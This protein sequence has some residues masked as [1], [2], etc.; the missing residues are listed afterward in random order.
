MTLAEYLISLGFKIDETSYRKFKEA[1][2]SIGSNTFKLG[3]LVAETSGAI[4]AF[5]TSVAEG[6]KHVAYSAGYINTT[7]A[8]FKGLQV[9]AEAVD[10]PMDAFTNAAA[11]W[12]NAVRLSNGALE[13]QAHRFTTSDDRGKQ[14]MATIN[15]LKKSGESFA[16]AF[17]D[18]SGRFNVPLDVFTAI[19]HHG[20]LVEK[21][22]DEVQKSFEKFGL[23]SAKLEEHLRLMKQV[24]DSWKNLK[25]SVDHL[26]TISADLFA[27]W[28]TSTLKHT[29]DVIVAFNQIDQKLGGWLSGAVGL[30]FAFG[31][32]A[33]ALTTVAKLLGV[34]WR[35]TG[36]PAV[37]RLLGLTAAAAVPAAAATTAATA[38]T[39]AAVVGGGGLL[40][41]MLGGLLKGGWGGMALFGWLH[42]RRSDM[43]DAFKK[44][45][46]REGT[47]EEVT[48][49]GLQRHQEEQQE[50]SEQ[51]VT[52]LARILGVLE[53]ADVGG[54]SPRARLPSD[55]PPLGATS[56]WGTSGAAKSGW[57]TGDR[58]KHGMDVLRSAFPD[59]PEV[60]ARALVARFAGV[61][62][63]GGPGSVNRQ[64]G[65][66]GA[67]GFGQWRGSRQNGVILGD[68]ESQWQHVIEELKTSE[69]R[70]LRTLMGAK[71]ALDA[72]TGAAQF[73][74]AEGW[75]GTSDA[76]VGKTMQMM[77]RIKNLPPTFKIQPDNSLGGSIMGKGASL[78]VHS[79]ITVNGTHDPEQVAR[80]VIAMQ[81]DSLQAIIRNNQGNTGNLAP[82]G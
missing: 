7:A 46:G 45:H 75:N 4:S 27:L 44:K 54:G 17:G 22:I 48:L 11:G 38:A 29:D 10:L 50:A 58:L 64:G 32:A 49:F 36:I 20:D 70:A 37:A 65:G 21:K 24:D 55:A 71:T 51:Q 60:S 72:A 39:T 67:I 16:V 82:V 13:E 78:T 77:E 59:M 34:V 53:R 42:S 12:A 79:Q 26:Q 33:I 3:A 19:W 15:G 61:E 5:V 31:G 40:R 76:F 1:L 43:E 52:L 62:A 81:E 69:W 9:A 14:M 47:S 25:L 8:A 57:W 56:A 2:G 18:V 41:G 63:P 35:L 80:R 73:E 30:S 28:A 74:R 6:A 68:A 66:R 23:D